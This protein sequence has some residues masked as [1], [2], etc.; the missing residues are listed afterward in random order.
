V[1]IGH[2]DGRVELRD[3]NEGSASEEKI[4]FLEDGNIF[5]DLAE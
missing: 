4:D 2:G 5:A 1:V 3:M